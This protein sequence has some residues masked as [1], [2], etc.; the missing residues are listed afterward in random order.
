MYV[1]MYVCT[2]YLLLVTCYLL[3]VTRYLL[4]VTYEGNR[5][6]ALPATIVSVIPTQPLSSVCM[7]TV[8]S[9]CFIKNSLYWFNKIQTL[10]RVVYITCLL[11]HYQQLTRSKAT[12]NWLDGGITDFLYKSS[13]YTVDCTL[14]LYAQLQWRGTWLTSARAPANHLWTLIVIDPCDALVQS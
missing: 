10:C 9:H 4:L 7:T 12:M 3:L 2:C 8:G 13:P 5:V 14:Q 11:V 6:N 1:C